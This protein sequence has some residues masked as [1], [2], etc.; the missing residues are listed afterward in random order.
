MSKPEHLIGLA[1]AGNYSIIGIHNPPEG[2]V[3]GDLPTPSIIGLPGEQLSDAPVS[4]RSRIFPDSVEVDFLTGMFSFDGKRYDW[5]MIEYGTE[6]A[7]AIGNCAIYSKVQEIGKL[8]PENS[9]FDH[10]KF[11]KSSLT[12]VPDDDSNLRNRL[13]KRLR[14]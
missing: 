5:R 13:R 14:K 4:V 9:I 1:V 8:D 11:L 6:V 12:R 3:I 7:K 10:D 2:L